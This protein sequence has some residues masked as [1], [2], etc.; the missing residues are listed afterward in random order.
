M[1]IRYGCAYDED[2]LQKIMESEKNLYI[3]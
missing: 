3:Y 2:T 1:R